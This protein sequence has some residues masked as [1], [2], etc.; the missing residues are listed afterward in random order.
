VFGANYITGVVEA[1]QNGN[2]S[3]TAK[4]KMTFKNGG[5]IEFGQSIMKLSSMGTSLTNECFFTKRPY[6]DRS[7]ILNL[8]LEWSE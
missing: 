8:K 3:G 7:I 5:A 4:F 2:W 1:Q 6:Y